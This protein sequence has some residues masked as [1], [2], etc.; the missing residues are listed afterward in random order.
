MPGPDVNLPMPG[1]VCVVLVAGD[2]LTA[3]NNRLAILAFLE[4]FPHLKKVPMFIT[5]ESWSGHYC[6]QL[7]MVRFLIA[8]QRQHSRTACLD[9]KNPLVTLFES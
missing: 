5:G 2:A 7:A 8:S 9:R 1:C 4:R 3:V 6:S